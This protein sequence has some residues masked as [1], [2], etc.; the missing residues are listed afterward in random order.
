MPSGQTERV[1]GRVLLVEGQE[2]KHSIGHLLDKHDY[3]TGC[4]ILA[5]EGYSQVL[6]D[7]KTRL[8]LNIDDIIGLIIDGDAKPENRWSAVRNLLMRSGYKA[9]PKTP[10]S[11]G[12][13][14]RQ[15]GKPIVGVWIM[16]DNASP[17]MLEDFAASLLPE[18]DSLWK[19]AVGAVAS[20]S[21]AERRFSDV[22]LSKAQIRTW[23]AW[24]HE[25]GMPIGLAIKSGKLD[26]MRASGVALTD[27]LVELFDL[28]PGE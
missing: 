6:A 23:L 8:L 21:N 1:H 12:T 10:S 17:G 14:V 2:D 3:H 16:P 27:W 7:L 20:I 22:H 9:V 19:R 15:E 13:T 5:F 25:P 18:G 24:Q 11:S 28:K 26:H 4:E